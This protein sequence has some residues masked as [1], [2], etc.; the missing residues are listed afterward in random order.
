[1]RC[2]HCKKKVGLVNF[3]CKCGNIY[4]TKCRFP[5]KHECEYDHKTE[6]VDKLR[7]DLPHIIAKK[8]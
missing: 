2:F 8:I 5:E 6:L 1:M 7:K 3:K 4:C